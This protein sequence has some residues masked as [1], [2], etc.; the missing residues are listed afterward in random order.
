[1]NGGK[2]TGAKVE[3][4]YSLKNNFGLFIFKSFSCCATKMGLMKIPD[5]ILFRSPIFR[6]KPP[7]ILL[8]SFLFFF[9]S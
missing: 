8:S 4:L 6:I 5:V 2:K 3:G 1:M 9:I 7:C